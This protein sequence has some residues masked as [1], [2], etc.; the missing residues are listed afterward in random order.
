MKKFALTTL[1]AAMLAAPTSQAVADAYIGEQMQSKLAALDAVSSIMAVV[2]Y[3]QMEPLSEAQLSQ[4]LGL[5]ITEG[6][7]FK[8][9]PIIGVVANKAQIEQIAALDGVR[10]VFANREMTLYNADAREITGVAD[11][12]T[13]GFAQRNGNNYTGKGITIMVN[14]SGVD[15]S[16]QDHFFGDT[17]VEN[18]QA[19]T[20]AS[21]ISITG[22][23]NGLVLTG[24]VNTDTN[25]GH[26]TH[27]A[28]TIAGNGAMSGGKYVGAAPDADLI[29]YGSGGGLFLLDTIGGFDFAINNLYSYNSPIRII[30]N[31][32][33]SSGKYEPLGPVSIATYKA[34]KLGILSVFAAGNDGPGEDSHNPYAQI[35]WGIS[36]GAGDKFGKLA[37]FSSRGLKGESGDFTMPDGTEWTYTNEVSIVA[38]GVDI[39]S[40][41]AVTNL[42][43][44]GGD[45]DIDAIETENV[46]F[47]TMISGTSM[48]TPHVS[49]II[50]LMLEANPEL[51]NLTIKK[52]LQESATNMPGYERWEVGGGYVNARS[53][54]AAALNYD[55]NHKVTVNN[56][57]GKTFNANALVATSDEQLNLELFYS[58]VGTPE[59]QT[60]EVGS[61]VAVVKA[62]ASTLANLTKLVLVAPDGTEY[63]GNLTTPVLSENM[64][65]SAP[66]MAGTWRIYVYGLTSLSGVSADPLGLTNGPGLP[67]FFDVA[68]N[69][70]ISGGY[71]GLDD[72]DGHPQQ[73]A[74]EFAVSNRLMDSLG[75]NFSPNAHLR[76]KDFA[77]YAMMGGAIRQYRDLLNEP[78][79]AVSSPGA[80]KPYMESVSVQGGA[81]KDNLRT[82]SPVLLD[83][84]QGQVS[85]FATMDKLDISYAMVQMLGLQGL[86]DEF[87]PAD[88]IVV[89]YKG[90]SVVLQDQHL[91]PAAL[92]GHV[93]LAINLSLINV[94]F[95]VKQS[96]FALEPTI[97]A[98]FAP[99]TKIT[100]AHYAVLAGRMFDYY[101]N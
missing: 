41:R 81:L 95:D 36:V 25:S 58:P 31:S 32:W 62:S 100:R 50:A 55:M 33:G 43:A 44:N 35:P 94:H 75:K 12:Q 51:D 23:T 64:R 82:Q 45:A 92:K 1:A 17:V 60:F 70:E 97:T 2:T 22:V 67:E 6:V 53:A 72:I 76:V 63:F 99:D 96:P 54:V 98:S 8:S 71:N 69:F 47:Y 90:Q 79:P 56:L 3:D 29:G 89:D 18:V 13:S 91:I 30:S 15:A 16:H 87:N 19:L 66:G 61:N 73:G 65:V 101:Y 52:L 84:V 10:S 24:Q 40:T 86:A 46:P 42:A 68:V 7:Q 26:G 39:I 74:I 83:A 88:D 28:G 27:V 49:G 38:P 48:A 37:G 21:A 9:L 85:A 59:M 77:R 93:Q 4:L 11:L 14:D 5:G 20:H 57:D 80:D 78:A 34:H